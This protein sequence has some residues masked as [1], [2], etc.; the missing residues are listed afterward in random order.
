MSVRPT[1]MRIA[2]VLVSTAMAGTSSPATWTMGMCVVAAST[3]SVTT[4]MYVEYWL[5]FDGAMPRKMAGMPKEPSGALILVPMFRADWAASA[6]SMSA[7]VPL[8][9]AANS[10]ARAMCDDDLR[11]EE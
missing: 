7:N 10:A 9:L 11:K 3:G 6:S 1:R 2:P 4:S 8:A 5:P